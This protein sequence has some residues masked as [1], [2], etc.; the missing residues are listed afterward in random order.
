MTVRSKD[1][2]KNIFDST[3][4]TAQENKQLFG[5]PWD[6]QRQIIA[7]NNHGTTKI[8]NYHSIVVCIIFHKISICRRIH[9]VLI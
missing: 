6:P 5:S 3:Q 4:H 8:Y 1:A 9:F 2:V 7:H